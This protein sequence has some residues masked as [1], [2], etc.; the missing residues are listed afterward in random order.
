MQLDLNSKVIKAT[1]WSSITEI[2]AKLFSPISIMVLAR[3]LTPDAFGALATITIVIT[4]AELFTDAGFQKY[5]IQFEFKNKEDLYRSTNVAFLTNL[6]LSILLV[7]II[8]YYREGIASLLGNDDLGMAIGIVSVSIPLAAFSSI[9][10]A[11]FKREFDFK[12]LFT[13]RIV[14]LIVPLIITI[15]FAILLENYW[16]LIIGTISLKLL[17]ALYL[18]H[19]SKWKPKLYFRFN[20]LKQMLSFTLWT[21]VEA[22][23]IW[24]SAYSGIFIVSRKLDAHYLGLYQTSI[25]LVVQIVTIITV[26]LTPV[27]FSTLSRLQNNDSEF[28]KMFLLFQSVVALIVI[29]IGFGMLSYKKFLTNLLLGQQWVE[30]SGFIGLF[31]LS[32][33]FTIVFSQ[34]NS[35]VFRAK[36]K[37][38]LSLLIQALFLVVFIPLLS[39]AV[40]RSY[41][42]LYITHSLTQFVKIIGSIAVMYYMFKISLF[43]MLKGTAAKIIVAVLMY[44][45][46]LLLKEVS[47]SILWSITSIGICILFYFGS[48]LLIKNERLFLIRLIGFIKSSAI[49]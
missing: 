5:L 48:L 17:S 10:L 40:N 18:T 38:K 23:S 9:Q 30:T 21:L 16:A 27:L 29:P 33:V 22:I 44:L 7:V 31:G 41:E 13:F 20:L 4:F 14:S 15:P 32:I 3:I 47:D 43:E 2:V 1:K 24:L 19:K 45:I 25:T 8:I 35:E 39:Y 28:R 37:P 49:Y 42:A 12:T 34:L 26:A 36:G 11:I 6:A 46:A